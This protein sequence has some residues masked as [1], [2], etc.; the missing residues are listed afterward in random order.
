MS[1]PR[2]YQAFVAGHDAPLIGARAATR[3]RGARMVPMSM[4][5]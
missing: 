1:V 2:P 4:A 5:V 3:G